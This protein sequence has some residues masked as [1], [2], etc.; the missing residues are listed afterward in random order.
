V[1]PQKT[2]GQYPALQERPQLAF[3]EARH[4]AV[5]Q[6]LPLEEILK[7]CGNHMVKNTLRRIPEQSRISLQRQAHSERRAPSRGD[8]R[9]VR[10]ARTEE[11]SP[12]NRTAVRVKATIP[13][14][15]GKPRA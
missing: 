15:N 5:L 6:T 12:T 14:G 7:L 8:R 9:A 13:A 11:I 2:V 10:T 3:D 1:H 4:V